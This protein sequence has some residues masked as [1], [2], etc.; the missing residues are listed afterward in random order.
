[1]AMTEEERIWLRKLIKNQKSDQQKELE[2]LSKGKSVSGNTT[3][4]KK[5]LEEHLVGTGRAG[6]TSTPQER[7]DRADKKEAHT[8]DVFDRVEEGVNARRLEDQE[9]RR[10][11]KGVRGVSEETVGTNFD[12]TRVNRA[13]AEMLNQ[14]VDREMIQA[15][16]DKE[17]D[18]QVTLQF[19]TKLRKNLSKDEFHACASAAIEQI[20]LQKK[21]VKGGEAYLAHFSS[22]HGSKT[23]LDDQIARVVTGVPS[24]QKYDPGSSL[25]VTLHDGTTATIPEYPSVGGELASASSRLNS[26]EAG[27]YLLEE[28]LSEAQ[29]LESYDRKADTYSVDLLTSNPEGFGEGVQKWSGISNNNFSNILGDTS[30]SLSDNFEYRAQN[31]EKVSNIKGGKVVIDRA[32]EGGYVPKTIF[33]DK[34]VQT[35]NVEKIAVGPAN[36]PVT[37]NPLKFADTHRKAEKLAAANELTKT[38][39]LGGSC[40]TDPVAKQQAVDEKKTLLDNKIKSANDPVKEGKL[41]ALAESAA[42][43]KS[44]EAMNAAWNAAKNAASQAEL[45]AKNALDLRNTAKTQSVNA[46]N[47][48]KLNQSNSNNQN[49]IAK[50]SALLEKEKD[51]ESKWALLEKARADLEK[52]RPFIP[53]PGTLPAQLVQAQ[54]AR[55]LALQ[56]AK[57]SLGDIPLVGEVATASE[58]HQATQKSNL[59]LADLAADKKSRAAEGKKA[60]LASKIEGHA[61]GGKGKTELDQLAE[62]AVKF[63]IADAQFQEIDKAEKLVDQ[64]KLD[65]TALE[66]NVLLKTNARD[67]AETALKNNAVPGNEAALR[68]TLILAKQALATAEN[69]AA[70]NKNQQQQLGAFLIDPKTP[71]KTDLVEVR[72][73][74]EEKLIA[75]RQKVKDAL[76]P[77]SDKE[78]PPDYSAIL[79]DVETAADQSEQAKIVATKAGKQAEAVRADAKLAKADLEEA[80]LKQE[81]AA[82]VIVKARAKSGNGGWTDDRVLQ[83]MNEALDTVEINRLEEA[84]Y[85]EL[86]EVKVNQEKQNKKNALTTAKAPKTGDGPTSPRERVEAQALEQKKEIDNYKLQLDDDLKDQAEQ[87]TQLAKQADEQLEKTKTANESTEKS[88][89]SLEQAKAVPAEKAK[90]LDEANQKSTQLKNELGPL[91][92]TKNRKAK[93]QKQTQQKRTTAENLLNEAKK[94]PPVTVRGKKSTALKNEQ[95]AKQA[96]LDAEGHESKASELKDKLVVDKQKAEQAEQA[97]IKAEQHLKVLEQGTGPEAQKLFDLATEKENQVHAAEKSRAKLENEVIKSQ[98][99]ASRNAHLLE[100]AQLKNAAGPKIEDCQRRFDSA[101]KQLEVDTAAMTLLTEELDNAVDLPQSEVIKLGN[102]I[103]EAQKKTESQEKVV[104]QLGSELA[105]YQDQA[106][107]AV[108]ASPQGLEQ[109]KNNIATAEKLAQEKADALDEAYNSCKELAVAAETAREQAFAGEKEEMQQASKQLSLLTKQ[110]SQAQ[111]T[112]GKTEQEAETVGKKAESARNLQKNKQ[113]QAD[114][115]NKEVQEAW[116]QEV[117]KAQKGFDGADKNF[118]KADGELKDAEKASTE[119]QQQIDSAND[120]V[121]QAKLA[122]EQADTESKESIKLAEEK[123]K[124]DQIAEEKEKKAQDESERVRNRVKD[125]VDDQKQT[126]EAHLELSYAEHEQRLTETLKDNGKPL[127]V[128]QADLAN[129]K[130]LLAKAKIDAAREAAFWHESSHDQAA[131]GAAHLKAKTLHDNANKLKSAWEKRASENNGPLTEKEKTVIAQVPRLKIS[132][133]KAKLKVDQS[134]IRTNS[135]KLVAESKALLITPAQLAV[136]EQQKEVDK[137]K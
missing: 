87:F 84:A 49:K 34:R 8:S 136:T 109:L 18:R 100:K 75:D 98:G 90:L 88:K 29:V 60:A 68:R 11:D 10:I 73:T 93:Q 101:A 27:L 19:P 15:A 133:D 137:L 26:G 126:A 112:V 82:K 110:A 122:K 67:L 31:L 4:A 32:L 12:G 103:I 130:I 111:E 52:L 25:N 17:I 28:A 96:K 115:L 105:D 2:E 7:K 127:T 79:N 119:K 91:N 102:K 13:N 9:S 44:L 69:A 131:S 3:E 53:D 33:P 92:Q 24:D 22:R 35:A 59:G 71:K 125:E 104:E 76:K 61:K 128:A 58:N 106:N 43:L 55:A 21:L 94:E 23:T 72:K 50:Q 66:N 78:T 46:L 65:Q 108:D 6:A 42:D 47:A 89:K 116:D 54:Q 40:H 134:V 118:N 129:K 48:Y 117:E 123:L 63:K 41:K 64:L 107:D 39:L 77:A 120:V 14:E 30:Y 97:R 121:N 95:S 81:L 124:Q 99:D 80:E 20:A 5:K 83:Y 62:S 16:I 51:L 1:M 86:N 70:V 74:A 113:Q 37:Q 114:K 38:E 135:A 132:M 85:L 45:A 57:D 36:A 56:N